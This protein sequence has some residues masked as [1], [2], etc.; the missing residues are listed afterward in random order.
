MVEN[1]TELSVPFYVALGNIHY[2]WDLESRYKKLSPDPDGTVFQYSAANM[3]KTGFTRDIHFKSPN[4]EW[5]RKK[6]QNYQFSVSWSRGLFWSQIASGVSNA[7]VA[8][9]RVCPLPLYNS[10]TAQL[11]L[12]NFEIESQMQLWI[13][14][15]CAVSEPIFLLYSDYTTTLVIECLL[16]LS[17]F[18]S[19]SEASTQRSLLRQFLREKNWPN[20]IFYFCP[21][22]LTSLCCFTLKCYISERIAR[23]FLDKPINLINISTIC[24]QWVL[25]LVHSAQNYCFFIPY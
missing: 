21:K 19:M 3:L 4:W 24:K 1:R 2:H 18:F 20:V 8:V 17:S 10:R 7:K 13:L 6:N 16:V 22:F 11:T 9:A 25:I 14:Q 5:K 23:L 12:T 15:N